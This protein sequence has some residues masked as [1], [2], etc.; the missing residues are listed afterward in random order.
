[1]RLRPGDTLIPAHGETPAYVLRISPKAASVRLVVTPREGLVVIVPKA[2]AGFDPTPALLARR[3]WIEASLAHFA[4]QGARFALSPAERLPEHVAF[5][6]T[7]EAW[8]VE[9]A[10]SP[11]RAASAR[12]SR[13]A[14]QVRGDS[15][16]PE[17]Q[18]AALHRWLQRAAALRLPP[19]LASHAERTGL[20][21]SAVG[22]RGQR[23][24]WGGCSAQGTVTLNRLLLFLEPPLVNAAMLHELAHLSVGD[25]SPRFWTEL[26]KID[27]DCRAHHDALAEAWRNVPAWAEP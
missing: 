12:V 20:V 6:A 19:L 5:S 26:E 18:V 11:G 9:Y 16:D 7:G 10:L 23:L 3:D 13:D 17:S 22:V 27:P 14:L 4:E 15:R 8:H 2:L 21:P 1:M 24:R 25:H